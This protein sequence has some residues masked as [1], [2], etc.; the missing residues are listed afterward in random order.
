[1]LWNLFSFRQFQLTKWGFFVHPR[2]D[3]SLELCR[4]FSGLVP[5]VGSVHGWIIS[6]PVLPSKVYAKSRGSLACRKEYLEAL[7]VPL[8]LT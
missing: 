5:S 2:L 4:T 8:V 3:S 1:M 6:L 7:M